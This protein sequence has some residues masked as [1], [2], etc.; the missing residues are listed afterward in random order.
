MDHWT[1]GM[2]YW[3]TGMDY[4]NTVLHMHDMDHGY[5]I[6]CGNFTISLLNHRF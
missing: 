5:D 4:W 1:T 3:N 2:D 6:M